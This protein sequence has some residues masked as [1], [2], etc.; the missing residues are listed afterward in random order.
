MEKK[1]MN[2]YIAFIDILGFKQMIETMPCS[3]IY[4]IYSKK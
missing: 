4:E 1:Y 3:E 2:C